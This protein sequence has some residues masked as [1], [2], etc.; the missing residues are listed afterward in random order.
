MA[1]IVIENTLDSPQSIVIS[2]D[3]GG[4]VL[5]RDL[6]PG[7]NTRISINALNAITIGAGDG[8][9]APADEIIPFFKSRYHG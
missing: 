2:E 3:V 4:E 6:K 9:A 7:E 5:R 1:I 8:K